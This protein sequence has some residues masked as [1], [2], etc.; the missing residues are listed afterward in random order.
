[1]PQIAPIHCYTATP[2]AIPTAEMPDDDSSS[3]SESEEAQ[4][5][6]AGSNVNTREPTHIIFQKAL[7]ESDV[8]ELEAQGEQCRWLLLYVPRCDW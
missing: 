5:H 2:A 8:A 1:M 7:S 4:P 3:E 6:P